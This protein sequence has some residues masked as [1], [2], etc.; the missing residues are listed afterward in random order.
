MTTVKIQLSA[1]NLL[2]ISA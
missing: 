1:D 2:N